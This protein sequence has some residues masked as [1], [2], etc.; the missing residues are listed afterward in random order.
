MKTDVVI[1]GTGN[2]AFKH[3][4]IVRKLYPKKSISLYNDKKEKLFQEIILKELIV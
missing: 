1:V 2:I 4:S 3:A